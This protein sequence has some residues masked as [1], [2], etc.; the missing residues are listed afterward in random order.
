MPRS[1][2]LMY[3]IVTGPSLILSCRFPW[4]L[5][6][7]VSGTL[8][9]FD[10]D[11]INLTCALGLLLTGWNSNGLTKIQPLY[12]ALNSRSIFTRHT[13]EELTKI[14]VKGENQRVMTTANL[15]NRGKVWRLLKLGPSFVYS[16]HVTIT[17]SPVN[18]CINFYE[19]MWISF[20]VIFYNS[21]FRTTFASS[22]FHLNFAFLWQVGQFSCAE[23]PS[24]LVL[25]M[26]RALIRGGLGPHLAYSNLLCPLWFSR[27]PFTVPF[28]HWTPMSIDS[29]HSS[30]HEVWIHSFTFRGIP[31]HMSHQ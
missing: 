27:F 21:H 29:V 6:H 13:T 2:P 1:S 12:A 23:D 8:F 9:P 14:Y 16:V 26:C 10:D 19:R 18:G 20:K 22:S 3:W 24:R 5:S 30:S 25:L 4:P 7:F 15:S 28:R 17:E 31:S 11:G